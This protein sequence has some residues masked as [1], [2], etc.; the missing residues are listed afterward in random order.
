MFDASI[1]L[2]PIFVNQS[3]LKSKKHLPKNGGKIHNVFSR[4]KM[5]PTNP[6]AHA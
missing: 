5:K 6:N 1:M 4:N 3:R 2:D